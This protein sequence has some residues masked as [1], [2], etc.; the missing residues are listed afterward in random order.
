[1]TDMSQPPI[2]STVRHPE[3][4]RSANIYEVNL[5]QYTPEGTFAAFEQHLP[6]LADMGVDI[7]WLMPIQPIGQRERKGSLGSCYSVSDYRA[8]NPEFGTLDD[9]RRLVQ[10]AHALGMRLIIDWVANHTAWD[11][12]WVGEHPEWYLKD[13]Q[14]RIHSYVYDNGKEREHWADVVGLDF[15]QPALHD[16][17]IDA[18]RFWLVEAGIDGFRCDVAGLVPLPFWERARAEFEAIRPVFMLAEWSAPEL[19]AHAFDMT[20]DW[21]LHDTMRKIAGGEGDADTLARHLETAAAAF[22]R[23][24]YRMS[25]TNNHDKNAWE[26]HDGEFFGEAF[27]LFAV[28]AATLPGMPLI[29]GGQEAGLDKRLKFFDKDPIDWKSFEH[30]GFYAGL[31]RLKHEHPA[32]GNGASGAPLQ[33]LATGS[34]QVFA[35]R[36]AAAGDAVTVVANLGAS[37]QQVAVEGLAEPLVL[38]PWGWHIAH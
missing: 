26:G 5:R 4:S 35:F 18:M 10:A 13:A 21:A 24:A 37:S 27:R 7:L 38:G 28:L 34:T 16:A 14:G 19:H 25:F 15:A 17:M 32:L 1:M 12:V 23:D 11:H 22:P 30:A 31:L 3:W 9:L 36:R 2:A 8:V 6:R 33:R 29:Y 20:Y